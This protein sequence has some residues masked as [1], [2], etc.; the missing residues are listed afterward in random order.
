MTTYRF[1]F[2]EK[3]E[4][5]RNIAFTVD[6]DNIEDAKAK[7]I[8]QSQYEDWDDLLESE[9]MSDTEQKMYPSDNDGQETEQLFLVNRF[10]NDE[11]IYTN[12]LK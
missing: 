6:A 7:A 5:W 11:L 12:E 9:F 2:Q 10:G 4:I 1:N 8:E 3:V